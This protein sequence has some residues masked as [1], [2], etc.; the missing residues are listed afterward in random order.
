MRSAPFGFDFV[1]E[2]SLLIISI[3]VGVNSNSLCRLVYLIVAIIDEN[4]TPYE[5]WIALMWYCTLS[6]EDDI[7]LNKYYDLFVKKYVGDSFPL[8]SCFFLTDSFNNLFKKWRSTYYCRECYTPGTLSYF[9]HP[10]T[11]Q[12]YKVFECLLENRAVTIERITQLTEISEQD[13]RKTFEDYS[14][15]SQN[16][17]SYYA[18]LYESV[19]QS[20]RMASV[21]TEY[22][23][24]LIIVP[25]KEDVPDRYTYYHK[26]QK[27]ELSLLGILLMLAT[28]SL[29]RQKS[30]QRTCPFVEEEYSAIVS[31]YDDKLPLILGKWNL[32][33][34]ILKHDLFPSI[35]DYLFLDKGEILSLSVLLGGNKEI[36][37]NVKSAALSTISKYSKICNDCNSAIQSSD[38]PEEF[39]NSSHYQFVQHKLN[40]IELS[41][42]YSDLESFAR[43]IISK[44]PKVTFAHISPKF[45]DLPVC[46]V[47][48]LFLDKKAEGFEF[49][50][51]LQSIESTLADEFTLLFY[52]GLLREN[53]H[54]AS[55]Y[56]LTAGFITNPS[57]VSPKDF[58]IQI[59]RSNDVIRKQLIEW[60]KGAT[61]YQSLA[62]EKMNQICEQL[63]RK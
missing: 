51:D 36:Y 20:D 53:N 32:F 45:K 27:Y 22:L 56:P 54:I 41:L 16:K 7:Q 2:A 6:S 42:R 44:K 18:E 55:D 57:P 3:S 39:L 48:K 50:E 4:L 5:F 33:R 52:V 58:L 25:T 43:H 60:I 28:I 13:I 24:H 34:D 37:D 19:Y 12:A 8:R 38:C 9:K 49:K 11:L 62:L 10:E 31:N 30:G 59:I 35:L 29:N 21:T 26:D 46:K 14:I 23:S 17:Y 40:E 1:S 15:T 61:S 47:H 63:D